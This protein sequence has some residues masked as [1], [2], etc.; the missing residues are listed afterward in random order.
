M[1]I[2]DGGV[3]RR[4]FSSRA[5][6]GMFQV[7]EATVVQKKHVEA[8]AV[9]VSESAGVGRHASDRST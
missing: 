3:E 6:C 2:G 7:D 9:E 4:D 5:V 1:G 8:L